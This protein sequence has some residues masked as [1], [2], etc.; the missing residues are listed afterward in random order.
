MMIFDKSKYH[1][2]PII[3][4]EEMFLFDCTRRQKMENVNTCKFRNFLSCD[5][6]GDVIRLSEC[7]K[8]V[9]KHLESFHLSSSNEIKDELDLLL[10]RAGE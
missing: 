2:K 4:E 3:K 7:N 9:R 6:K 1:R 8:D 10:F 5:C